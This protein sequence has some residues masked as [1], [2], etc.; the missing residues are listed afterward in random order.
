MQPHTWVVLLAVMP[1]ISCAARVDPPMALASRGIGAPAAGVP[2]ARGDVEPLVLDVH[3]RIMPA[4]SDASVQV[5]IEPDERSRSLD[6]LWWSQDGGGGAH[7]IALDGGRAAIRHQYAIRRLEP[8]EYEVAAVLTRV[9]GT[10]VRRST[11]V[12]VSG[13]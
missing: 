4:E 12:F 10:V 6:I 1:A 5:R 13:R 7:L 9:D 2:R 3:P 11:T 8:G